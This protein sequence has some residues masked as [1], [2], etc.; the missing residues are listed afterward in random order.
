MKGSQF[1]SEADTEVLLHGYEEYGETLTDR[2]RGMFAFVIWDKKQRRLFG[3]RDFGIKPF[4]YYKTA[5][6]ALLSLRKLNAS[7][8]IRVL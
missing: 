4:Y 1:A 3:A 6:G 7:S 5:D 2:L 8:T